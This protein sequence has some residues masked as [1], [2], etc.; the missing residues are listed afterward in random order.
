MKEADSEDHTLHESL[1]VTCPEEVNLQRQKVHDSMSVTCQ[2]KGIY[3]DRK[4]MTGCLE[5]GRG[6]GDRG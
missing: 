4:C 5:L 3:R 2:E 1:S 6:L